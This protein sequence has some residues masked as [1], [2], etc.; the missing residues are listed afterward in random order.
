VTFEQVG[1][2]GF[3]VRRLVIGLALDPAKPAQIV[4]HQ[5]DIVVIFPGDDRGG[6]I[7]STH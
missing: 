5:V 2:H 6:P 3:E 1:D 7:G 4:H